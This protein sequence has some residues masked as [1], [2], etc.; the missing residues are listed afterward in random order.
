[1]WPQR[2]QRPLFPPRA[3]LLPGPSF[4]SVSTF[5]HIWRNLL[6]T[7][8]MGIS[9]P[10]RDPYLPWS[11]Y[12][13]PWLR[14][15]PPQPGTQRVHTFLFDG[16]HGTVGGSDKCSTITWKVP[17]ALYLRV[18]SLA[19]PLSQYIPLGKEH[20]SLPPWKGV[21]CFIQ[22]RHANAYMLSW[23]VVGLEESKLKMGKNHQTQGEEHLKQL[24]G[25]GILRPCAVMVT[26]SWN[27]GVQA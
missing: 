16:I 2:Y 26:L 1:M 14:L 23:G 20:C 9:N 22:R 13:S 19:Y 8:Q 5:P 6:D 11:Q 7:H 27:T 17:I 15:L 21:E 3:L 18:F 12:S 24:L 25:M 4:L 10:S